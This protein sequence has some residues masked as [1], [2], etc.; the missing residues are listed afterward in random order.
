MIPLIRCT[1]QEAGTECVN[2]CII[3]DGQKIH[4]IA[5]KIVTVLC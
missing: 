5:Y 3:T 4:Y 1:K 2:V